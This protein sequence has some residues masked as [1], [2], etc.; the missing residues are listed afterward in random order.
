MPASS[1]AKGAQV[2]DHRREHA[3]RLF[4]SAFSKIWDKCRSPGRQ[5]DQLL[6]VRRM[7]SRRAMISPDGPAATAQLAADVDD[8]FFHILSLFGGILAAIDGA[9]FPQLVSQHEERHERRQGNPTAAWRTT[10][11]LPPPLGAGVEDAGQ[12]DQP[13]H[14]EQQLA[15]DSDSGRSRFAGHADAH[16]E[17]RGHHLKPDDREAE[18]DDAHAL[19]QT[20]DQLL[21][22]GEHPH[23]HARQ[24]FRR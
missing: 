2:A 7:P 8:E 12:E 10:P 11:Q 21:V 16:E 13:R 22:G 17:V 6:V 24:E 3:A 9:E 23:G 18:E 19:M 5:V 20:A 15:R 1:P 4:S 14:Q